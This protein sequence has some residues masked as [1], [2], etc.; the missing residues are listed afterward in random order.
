[1]LLKKIT[2]LFLIFITSSFSNVT[3]AQVYGTLSGTVVDKDNFKALQDV[4]IGIEK[5][6]I[7]TTTDSL[8]RFR[9]TNIPVGSYNLKISKVGYVN[10]T[11]Y[12]YLISSGN[13]N[14]INIELSSNTNIQAVSISANRSANASS[15]ITPLSVQR[16]TTEE[17]K[18]NPGGNFDIS[19]VIQSLPG[20][21]GTDG[22][23]G[24][25]RNDI[26]IRG[27]APNE[28]V[29][30]LDGIETPIINHFST[31]GS[32]GGP[33]GLLNV[34]FIQDVKLSTSAFDARF[35]NS[36][37]SVFQFTQKTGNP[38]KVQGNLRIQA[39]DA[40]LTLD[41]PLSKNGKTT[42]LASARR[43]YL[44]LL[45]K[46]IDLP[47][48]PNY[49][50]FQ[51]KITH[52]L[53]NKTTFNFI[54][55]GA[56]DKFRFGSIKDASP[57]KLYTLNNTPSI[58]QWNYTIGGSLKTQLNNGFLNVALSRNVLNNEINK[59]DE[60]QINDETKRRLRINSTETENKL[61]VD[62]N[63]ANEGWQWSYGAS[64]QYVETDNSFFNRYRIQVE[65][66][67]G[68]IIQ[69]GI[70]INSNSKINFLKYGAFAQLGKRFFDNKLSLNTGVRIDIN[71]F[72]ED[73]MNPIE[74]LSPRISLSYAISDYIK[75]NASVGRYY[76]LPVYTVLGFKD[77]NSLYPNK[78][79]KYI[80][81]DHYVTGFEYLLS[82][83]TR[84]TLEGFYKKYANYPVSVRDQISLAN[85][86]GDYNVVGNEKVVSNGEGRAYG[87][88]F[89]AQQKLT[90]KF[91]GILSYTIFKSEFSGANKKL[92]AAAWD[93]NQ[94][95]TATLGYKLP[96][97]FE[98]GLKFRY[99]GGAPYTPFDATASQTNY[100]TTGAGVFNYNQLNT[101]RLPS[102][103]Q[104]DVR[105]DKRWNYKNF[106]LN[107]FLD[108]SN[109]LR[110][111]TPSIP[112]Y[113][114]K[115]NADNTA[116]LT[117]DGQPIKLDGSNAIPFIL[118]D[119]DA[120]FTPS[121]G[122]IF[123]F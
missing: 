32:S 19:R 68:N 9:I 21:S 75:W 122:I 108:V 13:E 67:S 35:D 3:L 82:N 51:T 22:S 93:N 25:F 95:L 27:G 12:N 97:N 116:F 41:G 78:D 73:G 43:S 72:T 53:S 111:K 117:S 59:F 77:S 100:L 64:L 69:P 84:F 121:I 2:F 112:K 52:K 6:N 42:F 110:T 24:G 99:Q 45:F 76:K 83:S 16:M 66:G 92:V 96:R 5:T 38:N 90:E 79:N 107:A 40:A 39:T 28:N 86:G 98:I 120:Q 94:L 54:G 20:V 101:L 60:N 80:R 49:W 118:N 87:I 114:F 115:R 103:K 36:L 88:E 65:D 48:R 8:G 26:I 50:D 11:L 61:R 30:Y 29:F 109:F 89:F 113:T 46:L 17:I 102:F 31:Q 71:S 62:F 4:T 91:F 18:S 85:M 58:D 7:S 105:I 63:F 44:D 37:S 34:L 55:I 47:I 104:A 15:L 119:M 106:A 14:T 56:L 123:E 1:M 33:T 23:S 57:E 10:E 70:I 74:T 81:S